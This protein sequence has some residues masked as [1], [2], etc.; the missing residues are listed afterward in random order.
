MTE[1]DEFLGDRETDSTVSAG[2]EY[3][4]GNGHLGLI[5]ATPGA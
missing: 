4:P 3:G 2:H 5:L 1:R